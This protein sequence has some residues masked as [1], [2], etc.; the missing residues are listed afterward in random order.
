MKPS[1]VVW[2][3]LLE[4]SCQHPECLIW[5]LDFWIR[6]AQGVKS[7]LIVRVDAFVFHSH[8][9][10]CLLLFL[11]RASFIRYIPYRKGGWWRKRETEKERGLF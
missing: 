6:V 2:N 8:L 7:T 3:F 11:Q 1:F 5:I 9:Y 10:D 4:A